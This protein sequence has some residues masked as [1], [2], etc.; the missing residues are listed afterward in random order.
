M[1]S[2]EAEELVFKVEKNKNSPPFGGKVEEGEEEKILQF[3]SYIP[4]QEKHI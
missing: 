3:Q 4:T 1:S 2:S